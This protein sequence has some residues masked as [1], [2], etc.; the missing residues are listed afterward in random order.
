MAEIRVKRSRLSLPDLGGPSAPEQ[1][2]RV[3]ADNDGVDLES[4]NV[5]ELPVE[6]VAGR[7]VR[8]VSVL[9]DV[10]DDPKDKDYVLCTV[11]EMLLPAEDEQE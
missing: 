1:Y 4:A 9:R 5:R 2:V 8:T 6:V 11:E 10:R 7:R 3:I